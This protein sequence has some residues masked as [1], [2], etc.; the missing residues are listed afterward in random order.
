MLKDLEVTQV[1]PKLQSYSI[2]FP[3]G[4][5]SKEYLSQN[6]FG[7]IKMW[8]KSLDMKDLEPYP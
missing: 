2:T 5:G 3:L 8:I 7:F 1:L 4:A 6:Y